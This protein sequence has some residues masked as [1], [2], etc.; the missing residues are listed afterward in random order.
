[1]AAVDFFSAFQYKWAQTGSLFAMDDA[2][3]KLGWAF[4]GSTPPSVEQFNRAQQ[5]L[6]EKSNWLYGQLATVAAARGVTISGASLTGLQEVLA[7]YGQTSVVDATP[8]A[9]MQVGAFGLGS[10]A[11]THTFY[12]YP[13]DF[14]LMDARSGSVTVTGAVANGPSGAAPTT[15]SHI[16]EVSLRGGP[17]NISAKQE[18]FGYPG[19][20]NGEGSWIRYGTGG[21]GAR[22]WT[23]WEQV[24]TSRTI[25][26]A[27]TTLAGISR[28]ATTAEATAGSL[29]TV[30]VTPAGLAAAV[31]AASTTVVGK[32]RLATTA[33]AIAGSLATVAVTPAGLAAAVPS[34]STSAAGKS[35][36]ATIAE[37]A[38]GISAAIGVTP[39]GLAPLTTG[40]LLRTTVYQIVSGNQQ[41]SIDGGAFTT[42]GAT[43]FSTLSGTKSVEIEIHGGGAAGGSSGGTNASTVA[44][45]GGGGA[46]G[47]G[48]SIVAAPLSSIA[49]TVGEAGN[50]GV[51][52]ITVGGNGGATSFGA[53]LTA[54]GGGGGLGGAPVSVFPGLTNA[55]GPGASTNG[56][57]ISAGG[58][59]G[60]VGLAFS[61]GVVASGNGAPSVFGG[62]GGQ[63]SVANG[64]PAKAYGAGGGGAA[65]APNFG[66]G[67][68]GGAGGPGIVIVREFS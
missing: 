55:G 64:D 38:A 43:T 35:R 67:R 54:S 42:T 22:T 20:A 15:Y 25:P 65:T 31:P 61:L 50:P 4:I 19:Y 66:A 7:A 44:V 11:P 36:F 27:S 41:V 53:I 21:A 48:K 9:W 40:R 58:A 10:A 29:A 3:Y 18:L 49:V 6:D 34:A 37:T 33:E 16:L 17:A 47:Y 56:N 46:G 30:A 13:N 62:G 12:G 8:G 2:Q 24:Y 1:M 59:Y 32:S 14:N 60:G 68:I 23:A 28:L 45:G 52:G 5:V 57:V 63:A 51:A 26:T 39:A